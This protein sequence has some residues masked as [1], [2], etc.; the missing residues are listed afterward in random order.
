MS[1]VTPEETEH[2]PT[3]ILKLTILAPFPW[4]FAP[5]GCIWFKIDFVSP[6]FHQI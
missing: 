4:L 5:I 3:L 6:Y 1:H 2:I